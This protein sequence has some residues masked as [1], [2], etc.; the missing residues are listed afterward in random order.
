MTQP[1]YVLIMQSGPKP[2]EQYV[3]DQDVLFVGRDL[4]NDIVISDAEVSRRHA[5]L[6]RQPN[7]TYEIEDLG[8]TNGTF[9]N[10][11]RLVGKQV[12]SRGDVVMMGSNVLFEVELQSSDPN[13]TMVSAPPVQAPPP[14]VE[15]PPSPPQQPAF[16]GRVPQSPGATD[17]LTPAPQKKSSTGLI[18]GCV[19]LLVLCCIV[20]AGALWYIDSHY[21]WCNVLPV[22]PGC[23]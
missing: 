20:T 7:G 3:L 4:Q 6:M 17:Q 5:R 22:L 2:G 10:G 9:I 11:R 18:L 13:A 14:A 16:V 23:P 8:S 15:A 1:V 21:L 12:L 19:G